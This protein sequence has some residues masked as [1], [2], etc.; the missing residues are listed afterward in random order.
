[1]IAFRKLSIG[2]LRYILINHLLD[3]PTAS[4]AD[5]KQVELAIGKYYRMARLF[6]LLQLIGFCRTHICQELRA[7]ATELVRNYKLF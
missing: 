6:R 1:M 3:R 4:N 7:K 2:L 5:Q